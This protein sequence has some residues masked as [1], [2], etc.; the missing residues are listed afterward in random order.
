[1][2]LGIQNAEAEYLSLQEEILA[3]GVKLEY[4]ELEYDKKRRDM[5]SLILRQNQVEELTK[6]INSQIEIFCLETTRSSY[7]ID[8]PC[9]SEIKRNL[10]N[11]QFICKIFE[12]SHLETSF[13][14]LQ[15]LNSRFYKGIL[16]NWLHE[17]MI[18]HVRLSKCYQVAAGTEFV[19]PAPRHFASL[20]NK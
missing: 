1:M 14:G 11:R 9:S 10:T 5:D 13:I 18:F 19:M 12:Y 15:L 6:K 7:L 20:T 16:P 4:F 2:K 3:A 17:T 8:S